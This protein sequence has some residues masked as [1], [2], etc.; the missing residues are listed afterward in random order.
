[1]D[2]RGSPASA[3]SAEIQILQWGHKNCQS[4]KHRANPLK[5]P[6]GDG[7][8][9]LK[10][11]REVDP[12]VMVIIVSA[13]SATWK[14]EEAIRHGAYD[15]IE[16]PLEANRVLLAIKNALE[17]KNLRKELKAFRARSSKRCST[18]DHCS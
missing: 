11:M 2:S 1:M 14:A 18:A 4:V 8:D 13:F 16:K 6:D 3:D 17:V 10:R 9:L 5:L 7:M 12:G 15:F